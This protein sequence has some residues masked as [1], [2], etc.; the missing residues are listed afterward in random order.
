MNEN[1][2]DILNGVQSQISSFDNKANIL[3]SIVGIIFAL[4]LSFLDVFHAD[5]YL[6]KSNAFKVWY[7][8]FF[9]L[10]IIITISILVSLI[11]VIIPRSHKTK[12]KFFNYYKDINKMSIEEIKNS[13]NDSG[14][15]EVEIL[16]QIKINSKIC[17]QKHYLLEFGVIM[18][19]PFISCI[20]V[21]IMMIMFA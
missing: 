9:I 14:K 16:E 13:M 11:L 19:F 17:T 2:K 20:A 1:E 5:F 4:T 6:S 12:K 21:L 3:L 7:T 10:Y 8:L 18:L 15:K